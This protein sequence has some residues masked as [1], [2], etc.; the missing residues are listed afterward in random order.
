MP[1]TRPSV[2]FNARLDPVVYNVM[3]ERSQTDGVTKT[4]LLDKALRNYL[5]IPEKKTKKS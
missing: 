3:C 1:K 2:P 4:E 5:K